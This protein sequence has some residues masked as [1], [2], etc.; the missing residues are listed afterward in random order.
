M[1][2]DFVIERNIKYTSQI[3][4]PY[5]MNCLNSSEELLKYVVFAGTGS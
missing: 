2:D 5:V 3:F 4:D 1:L